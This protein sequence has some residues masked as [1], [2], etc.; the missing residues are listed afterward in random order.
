MDEHLALL[1]GVILPGALQRGINRPTREGQL[2]PLMIQLAA[3]ETK[4]KILKRIHDIEDHT[5]IRFTEA[6][7]EQLVGELIAVI[8]EFVDA[9][10][11]RKIAVRLGARALEPEVG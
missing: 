2:D 1:D 3:L 9:Q 10:T 4:G 5:K 6:G 7:L 11:L 8:A